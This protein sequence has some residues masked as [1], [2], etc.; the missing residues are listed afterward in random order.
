M[1]NISVKINSLVILTVSLF[2]AGSYKWIPVLMIFDLLYLIFLSKKL[3]I[4]EG[5][6]Q[7]L[8]IGIIIT[9]LVFMYNGSNTDLSK[10]LSVTVWGSFL[11][12]HKFCV[13]NRNIGQSFLMTFHILSLLAISDFVLFLSL[14]FDL[15][16]FLFDISSR[17]ISKSK[18]L[19]NLPR[20]T[21]L[22]GE[23][24]T[25]ATPLIITFLL[26]NKIKK[27][28]MLLYIFCT[29]II[30]SP[31]MLLGFSKLINR[32]NLV[33]FMILL[34]A[35][36]MLFYQRIHQIISFQDTSFLMRI[37]AFIKF[38]NQSKTHLFESETLYTDIGLWFELFSSYNFLGIYMLLL[39]TLKNRYWPLLFILK[40]KAYSGWPLLLASINFNRINEQE[41]N[42]S[43]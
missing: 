17:H 35:V 12:L 34:P 8:L 23:P 43:G 24:G 5:Y 22:F 39:I 33:K 11:I 18:G 6:N 19:F 26:S 21:G 25:Q 16:D 30:F 14:N 31:Y 20:S 42:N 28:D 37:E 10:F 29:V 41:N 2:E 15:S 9:V 27:S 40:I 3:Y 13:S 7:L 4:K 36:L 38:F 1:Q 32:K